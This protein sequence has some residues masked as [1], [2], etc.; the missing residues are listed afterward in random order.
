MTVT[1]TV[2]ISQIKG[3][4]MRPTL[5]PN[6]NST[7]W[8]LVKLFRPTNR[9]RNDIVLFRSPSDADTI[10]CKRVKGLA[11]D[12]LH[13]DKNSTKRETRKDLTLVPNGHLWVEGDNTH[14]VDSRSFGP[15]SDGLVLGKVV[16]IIWPPRRWG[17]DLNR[18]VGRDVLANNITITQGNV[19]ENYDY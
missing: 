17:T 7:D 9:E 1:E 11:N 18:W 3:T 5:N 8:V 19:D 13:L 12:A 2:H 10:Y 15:I 14:S 4:S 6:D 16:C